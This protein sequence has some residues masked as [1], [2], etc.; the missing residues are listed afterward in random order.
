MSTADRDTLKSTLPC[1]ILHDDSIKIFFFGGSTRFSKNICEIGVNS[2][3][4]GH[5]KNCHNF[6]LFFLFLFFLWSVRDFAV[7]FA[8]RRFVFNPLPADLE[9]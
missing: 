2:G 3:R 5:S 4:W 8:T 7:R 9:C 6:L 1:E